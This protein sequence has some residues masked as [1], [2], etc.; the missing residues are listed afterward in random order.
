MIDQVIF[1]P[2]HYRFSQLWKSILNY[3]LG[4]W[5][6]SQCGELHVCQILLYLA[7]A[8]PECQS[9]CCTRVSKYLLHQSIKVL[10]RTE[11][12]S[13]CCT[14]V[15][16]S[17]LDQR[18]KVLTEPLCQSTC[19]T[20]VSKYFL[21]QSVKFLA[22]TRV[23][24][25][26]QDHSVKVLAAPQCQSPCRTIVSKYLHITDATTV[27]SLKM[28]VISPGVSIRVEGLATPSESLHI[29]C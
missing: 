9:T 26:L 6:N 8:G 20:G 23:P 10:V 12:Q 7:L 25:Y 18:A 19:K 29:H 4:F 22:R 21:D 2:K 1:K 16:M 28:L 27:K 13:T 5:V 17:W 11:C 15:S 24:Q 3:F 14:R